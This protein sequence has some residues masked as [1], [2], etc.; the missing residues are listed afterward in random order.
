MEIVLVSK[1]LNF[2]EKPQIDIK[3][4]SKI[5]Q[6]FNLPPRPQYVLINVKNMLKYHVIS[7]TK[8]ISFTL[9]TDSTQYSIKVNFDIF[10]EIIT[11]KNSSLLPFKKTD[12][13]DKTNL[14]QSAA[15]LPH[16]KLT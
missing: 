16:L 7:M 13:Y 11:N 2:S 9:S 10:T 14:V 4:D 1:D 12:W 5:I 3:H 8:E 6:Q 15:N